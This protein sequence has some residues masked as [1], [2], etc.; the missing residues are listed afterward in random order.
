M[1]AGAPGQ[2]KTHFTDVHSEKNYPNICFFQ[3]KRNAWNY[4]SVA[5]AIHNILT[6]VAKPANSW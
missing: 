3:W 2:K 5:K 6:D 4:H 1:A